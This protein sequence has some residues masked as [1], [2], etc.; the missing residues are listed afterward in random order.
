MGPAQHVARE[1][2]SDDPAIKE[3]MAQQ[4]Q[5]EPP[6][7]SGHVEHQRVAHRL[8]RPLQ[9]KAYKPVFLVVVKLLDVVVSVRAEVVQPGDKPCAKVGSFG[10]DQDP[11]K[12]Q[13]EKYEANC[14]SEPSQHR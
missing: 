8:A 6:G 11:V 5:R 10:N 7:A 13:R 2:E 12:E 9:R 4:G 3:G 1:V 14:E